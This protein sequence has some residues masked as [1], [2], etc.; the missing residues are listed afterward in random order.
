MV[1]KY[2]LNSWEVDLSTALKCFFELPGGAAAHG[3]FNGE[4]FDLKVENSL[5]FNCL[6]AKSRKPGT[7]GLAILILVLRY[8]V[9]LV[10]F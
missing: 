9:N 2:V 7:P 5:A 6:S 10:E 8:N 4:H 3:P 1:L